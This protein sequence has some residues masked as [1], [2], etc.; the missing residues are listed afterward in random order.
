[1]TLPTL[2][3]RWPWHPAAPTYGEP[4]KPTTYAMCRQGRATQQAGSTARSINS[5]MLRQM[6][7]LW[8]RDAT[9]SDYIAA[10]VKNYGQPRITENTRS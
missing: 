10:A 7:R 6:R 4:M 2:S 1:M 9:R 5:R 8:G 3:P